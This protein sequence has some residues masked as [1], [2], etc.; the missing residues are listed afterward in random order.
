VTN[1]YWSRGGVGGPG[2]A[3]ACPELA[4]MPVSSTLLTT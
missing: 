1:L 3:R 2:S 4:A